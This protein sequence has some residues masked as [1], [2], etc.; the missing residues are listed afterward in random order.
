M[1]RFD[2]I[3]FISQVDFIKSRGEI[4]ASFIVFVLS[5]HQKEI[6]LKVKCNEILID[7][8][9]SEVHKID[10]IEFVPI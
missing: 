9:K 3:F 10:G 8:D 1:A 4:L 7:L 2:T 5:D 6:S